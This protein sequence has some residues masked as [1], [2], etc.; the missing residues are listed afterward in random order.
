M[1]D[2]A[3]PSWPATPR[4]GRRLFAGTAQWYARF[5]PPYPTELLDDLVSRAGITGPGPTMYLVDLA[6][7]TGELALPLHTRFARVRAVDIEPDMIDLART[8]AAAVG[9]DNIGFVVGRAED[10]EVPAGSVDLVTVG[11]AFHRL[12]RP[13]MAARVLQWLAPGRCVAVVGSS[14][15]WSGRAQWQATVVKVLDRFTRH[16][17]DTATAAGPRLTHEQVLVEAGYVDVAEYRFPVEH[18]WASLEDYMGYLRSTSVAG[19]LNDPAVLEAFTAELQKRLGGVDLVE[20][21]DHY[22]ILG[23]RPGAGCN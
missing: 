8:K 9:A 18:Q 12:D 19:A 2:S 22:Y 13:A 5:R 15:V 1:S 16:P 7:G 11:N 6:C 10:L 21:V 17:H 14:S 3:V 4:Y 20:I 23:R